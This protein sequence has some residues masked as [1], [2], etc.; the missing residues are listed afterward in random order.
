MVGMWD[1]GVVVCGD[2]FLG[3]SPSSPNYVF[4]SRHTATGTLL[5]FRVLNAGGTYEVY[6]VT[7][8]IY[9]GPD[10]LV[11]VVG[12]RPFPDRML[13]VPAL[14]RLSPATGAQLSLHRFGAPNASISVE[15]IDCTWSNQ[16]VSVLTTL[17]PVGFPFPRQAFV[18]FAA[19][20][21]YIR[22]GYDLALLSVNQQDAALVG[23]G[24]YGG[25][26]FDNAGSLAM[27]GGE[28][29]VVGVSDLLWNSTGTSDGSQSFVVVSTDLC[30]P[31][32]PGFYAVPSTVVPPTCDGVAFPGVCDAGFYCDGVSEFRC[33]GN[34]TCPAGLQSQP[35][36][37]QGQH[38][39]FNQTSCMCSTHPPPPSDEPGTTWWT[40]GRLALVIAI[41]ACLV[42]FSTIYCCIKD[43]PRR[44]SRLPFL[45]SANDSIVSVPP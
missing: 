18:Q 17:R 43:R 25:F 31:A 12:R 33:L 27:A 15:P 24:T 40:S 35:T 3:Q 8:G 11:V 4:V 36:C 19:S 10:A 23:L 6:A 41:A 5:Y 14:V 21:G 39:V 26:G 1:G 34:L 22:A 32:T 16:T 29:V 2:L 30:A 7:R 13:G 28:V 38:V 45:N 42:F 37:S 20:T 44:L 9:M